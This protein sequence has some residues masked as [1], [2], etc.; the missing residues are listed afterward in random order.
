[1]KISSDYRLTSNNYYEEVSDKHQI[2]VGHSYNSGMAHYNSWVN[3][4]NGLNKKT[5]PY[6]ITLS[7]VIHEHFDPKYGCKFIDPLFDRYLIP[8]TLENE[9]WLIEQDGKFYD[10]LGR[11]YS[12]EEPP[13]KIEWRG[14]FL[15]APYS[16]KQIESTI[17]LVRALCET[18]EIPRK[19]IGDCTQKVRPI[20]FNGVTYKSNYYKEYL[21]LSPAFDYL[22]F[23]YGIEKN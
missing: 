5:T 11:I 19:V 21:D 14:K 22:S 13:I 16:N 6:T 8:I 1:M 20:E 9:G 15:W 3:R 18:F 10:W 7:G 2:V 4:M 23:R 12:R 17:E